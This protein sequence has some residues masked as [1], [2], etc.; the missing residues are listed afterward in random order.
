MFRTS[1]HDG[2][3]RLPAGNHREV[4]PIRSVAFRRWL[5]LIYFRHQEGAPGGQTLTDALGVL[6]GLAL[7]DGDEHEVHLRLAGHGDDIYLDLADADWRAIR[8][9]VPHGWDVVADPPVRFRRARGMLPLPDPVTGGSLDLLRPF[10]NVVDD[11]W[12]LLLGWIVGA[13]RPRGPYA[14]LLVHGEREAPSPPLSVSPARSSIRT[15]LRCAERLGTGGP[16]RR[17]AERASRRLRQCLSPLAGAVRRSR[18]A[19]DWLGIRC[20]RA[21]HGHR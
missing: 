9:S 16:D 15:R 14:V 19:C 13:L 11:D 6:E 1:A 10:A 7:F 20:A 4:W 21:L 17:G 8:P 5:S 12:P 2:Y 18:A 3:V